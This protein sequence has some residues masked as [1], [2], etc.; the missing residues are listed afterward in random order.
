MKKTTFFLFVLLV[1]SVYWQVNAQKDRY[2]TARGV[3]AS[4]FQN[5]EQ[6]RALNAIVYNTTHAFNSGAE[7]T[8]TAG[9]PNHSMGDAILLAGTERQLIDLTVDIFNLASAAPFNLTVRVYT[10]CPTSGATGPCG[11]GPG[12][13]VPG[14]TFTQAVTPGPLGFIY[15]TTLTFPTP[16]NVSTEVDNTIT[17]MLTASRNDV[18]WRLGETPVVG[19]MPVG[20]TGN[21]LITRCGS[22]TAT[23]GCN[24]NF[25]VP[26]N[27]AM[28]IRASGPPPNDLCANAIVVNNG[29]YNGYTSFGT[30]DAPAGACGTPTGT[31]PDVWYMF[32][33][34]SGPGMNVTATTC[35]PNTNYDTK[36]S[37]YRGV[38]GALVCVGGNDDDFSCPSSAL[39]S[40]VNFTTDGSSNYYIMVHGF[41]TSNGVFDLTVSGIIIGAAP[42]IACPSDITINTDAGQ[43]GA[44]M[45]FSGTAIDA[46]DGDISA[47]IIA[48][49]PSGSFFPVGTTTVTMEVTDSDGNTVSC[50]FDITVE[51]NEDPVIAC[52]DITVQ[53]DANGDA[54]IFPDDVA[55]A[56]DNC[57]GVT[58]QFGAGPTP[59]TLN[60]LFNSNNGQS[61]NMFNTMSMTDIIIDSFDINIDAGPRNVDIY[62]KVGSYVGS[63][64]NAGDW[65]LGASVAVVGAGLNVPT[66]LNL[67][68]NIAVPASQLTAFYITDTAGTALNYTNGTTVG[69]FWFGDANLEVYEGIGRSLPLFGG[70]IFSPRNINANIIYEIDSPFEPSLDFTCMNV[71]PNNVIVT[72][73]DAAGNTSTCNAVVT[74][75]DNIAPVISCIGEPATVTDTVSD[76]PGL[77]IDTG[78]G[79]EVVTSIIT[80]ADDQVI[81]N[82]NVDLNISHTWVGDMVI[83]LESPA[84]TMSTLFFGTTTDCAGDNIV[85][86]LDDDAAN[87]V[88]LEC[89]G[90]TPTINGT[91]SPSS[92]LSVFNG[93]S[94][95]GDWTITITDN[96]VGFDSGLFNS[97]ALHYSYDAVATPY[98]AVLDGTTGTV[99]VDLAD[100]LVSVDEACGYTVTTGGGAPIP[101]SITTLFATNNNGAQGGAVYFD[102]TVGPEDIS[103]LDIDINT[104][105]AGA[106]TMEV[107]T[108]VGTYVGNEGNSGAWTL[109]ANGSGTASGTV[110][111]PSNAVL[112]VPIILTA[113]TTYGMALVLD[114]THG[115]YYTN[116]DGTNQNYSNADVSLSLG[117]ASN[118]PFDGAPFSPRVFNG[119]LNYEIGEPAS[120][121]I[122]F[123]CSQL[124]LNEVEITVT[125]DSGN[126]S[127]CTATVNVIDNTDPIL[128]CMDAT[129]EL[130]ENGMAE[131]T[132]DLFIDT[133]NSFD[134]C[135]ITITAVDV[136]DVTCDDIGT[137]ITVTVFASDASGNLASCTATLTVVDLLGPAIEGCPADQ[138][139][140]PGPL[141]LFYELPDYWALGGIT[142]VDNCTDPVTDFSQTPAAGTLLPDGVYTVSICATDE[143]GNEGCCTF[144]L[145]I[146]SVLGKDDNLLDIS[147]IVIYPNPA[148]AVVSISNPKAIPFESATI[149]D[150]NG[151]LVKV[152]NLKDMGTEKTLDVSMLSSATYLVLIQGENGSITKQLIK[153]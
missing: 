97:W 110:D 9:G 13:L 82:L 54:T 81:T 68:M 59:V 76:S 28:T 16:V 141:N 14:S 139:V 115:H 35:S 118:V 112:D 26:N 22:V 17:V 145:T 12:I 78:G 119:T 62:Y 127:T 109:S 122:E 120:T 137:A 93:E 134:A 53:L 147:T 142:A 103:V 99:V 123:D 49:P 89:A 47:N 124:G 32:D 64:N 57:P 153:E 107:Y 65:T 72:A 132:P 60:G 95:L 21:G 45:N 61:G 114:A 130:D 140:D 111:T 80:I 42:V 31:A 128:V 1:T 38:C 55:T 51:D 58:L 75:E 44:V 98:D 102:V 116:G 83:T 3:D 92:P 152:Y 48:T 66:P 34:I 19:G 33:D 94:T 41:S 4:S 77:P 50:D 90:S 125:D 52:Q 43:C 18:Y 136:T 23:N 104:A 113:G 144:E 106:F 146:E 11:S 10:A 6:N 20:E 70:S 149:Y 91:F 96:F 108:L 8:T 5:S 143:Y 24:R 30:I 15:Q 135:G 69:N 138:T 73:T 37:V 40:T 7:I 129:V 46:E 84:G 56:T 131:V 105:D 86:T 29:T 67:D 150:L 101:G 63:E 133:A 88:D 100:L 2:A 151:R 27:F 148:K 126:S 79:T 25:G 71:G 85:A 121:T 87:P 117:A 74:V 36:I 39:Q